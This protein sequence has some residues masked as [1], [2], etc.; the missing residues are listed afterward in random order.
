MSVTYEQFAKSKPR[1]KFWSDTEQKIF[2][3]SDIKKMINWDWNKISEQDEFN[4]LMLEF[5]CYRKYGIPCDL[6]EIQKTIFI[7]DN[8]VHN[9]DCEFATGR[10]CNCWCGEKYHGLKGHGALIKK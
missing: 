3:K 9:F 10:S 4:R 5:C 1:T 7:R 6:E 8:Q 2:T